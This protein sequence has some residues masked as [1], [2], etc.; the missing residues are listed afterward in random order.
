L[1]NL[2]IVTSQLNSGLS[3]GAWAHKKKA[4]NAESKLLLNARLVDEETWD[5]AA[6]DA[7]GEWLADV[8]AKTW[9]GPAAENWQS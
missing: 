4:L 1:G 8:L 6:I 3:N 9:P 5:E 2:T 7:R